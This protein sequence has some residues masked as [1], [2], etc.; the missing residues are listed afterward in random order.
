MVGPYTKALVKG[1]IAIITAISFG[2]FSYGN[3]TRK[4]EPS[5][6]CY[7]SYNSVDA[8]PA[9]AMPGNYDSWINVSIRFR[10]LFVLQFW[11]NVSKIICILP[12]EIYF[13]RQHRKRSN[14]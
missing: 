5:F 12:L 2:I 6:D 14:D 7:A 9:D 4:V 13:T 8:I 11:L 10:V 1:I 3:I